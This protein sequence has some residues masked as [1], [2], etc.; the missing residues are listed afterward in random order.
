MS[1]YETLS[2]LGVLSRKWLRRDFLFRRRAVTQLV[3]ASGFSE[4]MA[5]EMLDA[6]F[7]EL[8]VLKLKALLRAELQRPAA[9]DGFVKDSRNKRL[10]HAKGPHTILHIFSAN[11][12][13]A[14]VTSFVMGLLIGS[15]NIGKVSRRDKGILGLY[16]DSLKAHDRTLWGRCNLMQGRGKISRYAK[17]VG[18]VVAYGD[19]ESLDE[20][21][22]CV[23]A[24]TSF[25]GYGHRVSFGL[26]LHEKLRNGEAVRLAK[27]TAYDVWMADQRGCL[28]PVLVFAQQGGSVSPEDFARLVAIELERIEKSERSKP[29]RGI[30]D[31]LAVNRLRNLLRMRALKGGKV[32]YWM[33]DT[34]GRWAV[35]YDEK[36]EAEFSSGAQILRVK[37]FKKLS[38][39]EGVLQKM[40]RSL[41]AVFLEC[42]PTHRKQIAEWLSLFGVNRI[43]RAGQLQKPPITWHHDGRPNLANWL[44]WV[45]LEG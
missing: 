30:A 34:P 31:S 1:T 32:G 38:D 40:S 13:N 14:A 16:L 23:P 6:L 21:Q 33:S 36:N 25:V 42:A 11:V 37:G 24:K 28:S 22:K 12:P 39:I 5:Q 27:K 15:R 17:E 7:S 20:I 41:Q 44:T 26:V 43:C 9:L 8:T 4:K 35:G 10:V 19:D 29:R 18:L 2:V 45:D 3:R